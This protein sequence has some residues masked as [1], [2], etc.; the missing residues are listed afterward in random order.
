MGRIELVVFDMAGTTLR[1]DDGVNRVIRESLA[2]AGLK[3]DPAEVNRVMGLPKR[4]ALSILI[5]HYGRTQDLGPR[6]DEIHAD[7]VRRS[8]VFYTTDPSI[9]EVEGASDLFRSLRQAGVRVAL[10]TGFDRRITDAILDRLGWLD[11]VD[12][13]ISSDEVERGRPH[14]DMIR[15]LMKR[16]GIVESKTIAK[17]GDTPADLGEGQAAGCGVNVGVIG[18]THS[19]AELEACPHTHLI[20]D[21]HQLLEI[22]GLAEV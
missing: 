14:P 13:T 9:R 15:A 22:L 16:L 1:D 5:E 2:A 18:A 4:Q 11:R 21:L 10:N 6:V 17:V 8:V 12:A 19:R 7:L 3:A 20:E